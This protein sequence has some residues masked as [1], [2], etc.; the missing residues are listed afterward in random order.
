M[1]TMNSKHPEVYMWR[2]W[3]PA[4]TYSH[5]IKRYFTAAD[6]KKLVANIEQKLAGYLGSKHVLLM[7]SG[8]T[9][10]F[11]ALRALLPK[12]DGEIL[13]PSLV[14]EVVPYAVHAAG[15]KPRFLEVN[16][17][18]FNIDEG[19]IESRISDKTEAIIAVH[20]F[21]K[22]CNMERISQVA[23]AHHLL[24]IEDAAQALGGEY[25][26]R[27]AGTLGDIGILSFNNKVV[28]ACRG[29]AIVTDNDN[30]F[31]KLRRY[32][33]ENC[34]LVRKNFLRQLAR[35]WFL[36]KYPKLAIAIAEKLPSSSEL[37]ISWELNLITPILLE[38]LL[39]SLNNILV[40][41]RDNFALYAEYLT[42]KQIHKPLQDSGS[43]GTFYTIKVEHS[44]RDIIRGELHERG[45]CTAVLAEG[46]HQKYE[47]EVSLPVTDTVAQTMFSFPTDANLGQAE[48]RFISNTVNNLC[49][50]T[51]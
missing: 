16:S 10:I 23:I 19:L 24:L 1:N 37:A 9:A 42:A 50:G 11:T 6:L 46:T 20:Q 41:R 18:T 34:L 35:S 28:D 15:K 3:F 47:P 36:S 40:K 39:P 5:V 38:Y 44:I 17:Q 32:R 30:F 4:K 49:E 27:K 8:T 33:D 25:R 7:P 22:L 21:G 31:N 48:I 12:S 26:G 29:G 45:I 2:P 14:C 51:Q 43:C 13:L